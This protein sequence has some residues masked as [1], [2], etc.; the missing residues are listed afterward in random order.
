LGSQG[1]SSRLSP[2]KG[3]KG[4]LVKKYFGV[5][6]CESNVKMKS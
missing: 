3:Q 1:N 4:S 6:F 5:R 2:N